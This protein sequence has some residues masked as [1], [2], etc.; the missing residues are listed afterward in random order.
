MIITADQG[1]VASDFWMRAIPQTACSNNASPDNIK[2]I[3]R[4][5]TSTSADDPSTTG[6][7][8]TNECVDE[9]VSDLVPWVVKNAASGTSLPEA[10]ALGRNSDN[11]N[12]WMMNSTSM[13]V[14]WNDPSLLQVYNND[15][16]FTDTSGVVR[17]D[18][19]D[20]WVM[21]VIETAMPIPHPIH[22]H[23]H[24]VSFLFPFLAYVLNASERTSREHG[25]PEIRTAG[26]SS[27]HAQ[28][29]GKVVPADLYACSSTSSPRE[30]GRT[31]RR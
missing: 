22:L 23:G 30:P 26:R 9:D 17:L 4:Y 14:E 5:S 24:D 21:F 19:A 27:R 16:D 29:M 20:E 10:V 12:R 2:G 15:S 31:T 18:T 25:L 8:Y 28:S 3:V 1:A 13:V 11:L 7:D 6:Y